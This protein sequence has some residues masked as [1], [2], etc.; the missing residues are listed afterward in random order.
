M[1]R[2][3]ALLYKLLPKVGPLRPLEFKAPTKEAEALFL[4]SFT[5]TRERYRAALDALSARRLDLPN[6]DFD[7]GKPTARGEYSL[8][9]KTYAELLHRLTQEKAAPPS[10]ALRRNINAFYAG[11]PTRVS[12]RKERKRAEKVKEA[13]VDL[14]K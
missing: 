7:T 9:D 12:G 8:A 2:F 5:G 4:E 3:L 10:A 13:L 1:A 6:T 11:P 14:N